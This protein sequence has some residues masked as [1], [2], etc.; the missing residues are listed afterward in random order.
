MATAAIGP[1]FITQTTVFT[2]KLFTDFGFAILVSILIDMVVQLLIWRTTA[3]TGKP[4]PVFVNQVIPGMGYVLIGLITI[5]GLI[6]NI[7]NMGGCGLAVFSLL[8][9]PFGYGAF[10][11]LVVAIFIFW[12]K[13]FGRAMDVFVKLLGILMIGLMCFIVFQ[14][15]PP[16]FQMAKN[17]VLPKQVDFLVIITLVGGTVGGYISFAGAQRMLDSGLGG[18]NH[19]QQV[20]RGAITGILLAGVMRVLLFAAVAGAVSKGVVLPAENPAAYVFEWAAGKGGRMVF[21]VILWCASITS[22]IAS[23][24]TSVSFLG[25]G[26]PIVVKNFRVAVVLFM[27]FSTVVFIVLGSPTK[28]LV[29][30]GTFNGLVLPLALCCVLWGIFKNNQFPQLKKPHW[31]LINGWVIALI[32]LLSGGYGIML[33]FTTY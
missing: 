1:G 2:G 15:Q 31:L 28:L 32:L 7:G 26:S 21:G 11:S 6:F 23:A 33:F 10:L 12:V 8:G 20:N 4:A 30:A 14:S 13:Q 3:I 25:T 9:M 16:W 22:V 5:G 24:Y 19:L 29:M 27:L 18:H 17:A